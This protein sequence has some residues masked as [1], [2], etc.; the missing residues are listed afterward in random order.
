MNKINVNEID[1]SKLNKL[2]VKSSENTVYLDDKNEKIYKMFLSKDL[3]LSKKK[4]ENL[5]VFNGIKKDINIVIPEHK[6]MSNGTLI[7]T[8]ERY[9]KGDDLKDINHRF[10]NI[11]DKILFCLDMSKTLEEIHKEN[12][13]VSDINPGNIRIGEDKKAYYIDI[14][15]AGINGSSPLATSKILLNYIRNVKLDTKNVTKELDRITMM[16][17]IFETLFNKEFYYIT[18]YE[19]MSRAEKIKT[20]MD[21]VSYY[22]VI[23]TNQKNIDMPYLHEIISDCDVKKYKK[24][25]R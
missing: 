20:L 16:M 14:L 10:S 4:E 17:L 2:D 13:V 9:I 11:Y 8:I 19:Y 15:N 3:D 21:L 18:Y 22:E 1:F 7:G 23:R 12:I 24:E 6:I 5:E 25:M